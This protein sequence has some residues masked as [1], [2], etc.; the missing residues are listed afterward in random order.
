MDHLVTCCELVYIL[1]DRLNINLDFDTS[2]VNIGG[3]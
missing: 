1:L 3:K 2:F